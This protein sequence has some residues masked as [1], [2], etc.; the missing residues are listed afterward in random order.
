MKRPSHG[1]VVAYLALVLAMSGT[2]YAATGGAF[3]LGH[4]NTA[5]ATS[6]LTTTA[7]GPA[8]SLHAPSGKP[9]LGVN[10]KAQITNLN[11]NYL[12]G[13][14]STAIHPVTL[15]A[16]NSSSALYGTTWTNVTNM[17]GTISI[18][19]GRSR[20]TIFSYSA[21]C[22]VIGGS[23]GDWGVIQILV[24]GTAVTPNATNSTDF[25]FCTEDAGTH[26]VSAATQGY[27]VLTPGNHTVQVQTITVTGGSAQTRLDDMQLSVVAY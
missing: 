25:A 2:A 16:Q 21:E 27:R 15:V 11:A 22:V 17:S 18:P 1:T 10:T 13:L 20:P 3:I 8:L 24:D 6:T 26:W 12:N 7:P 4:A 5:G 9:A 23:D 19:A 14:S